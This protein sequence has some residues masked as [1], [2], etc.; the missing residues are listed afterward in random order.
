MATWTIKD[1]T[2]RLLPHFVAGSKIAVGRKLLSSRFDVFRFAVSASY[3]ETFERAVL[4]VLA[5]NGWQIVRTHARRGGGRR[6]GR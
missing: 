1:S 6:A 4:Q 3:R 2:G 5:Q